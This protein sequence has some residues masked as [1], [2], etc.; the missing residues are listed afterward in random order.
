MIQNTVDYTDA[1]EFL[2]LF[3]QVQAL[4]IIVKNLKASSCGKKEDIAEI[5]DILLFELF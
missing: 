3:S 5:V 1:F 4:D 2:T